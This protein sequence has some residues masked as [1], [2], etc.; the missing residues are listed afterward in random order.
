MV[1]L[2]SEKIDQWLSSQENQRDGFE[3]ERS[4]TQAMQEISLEVFQLSVG[5]VPK[6]K[7]QKKTS[8][9]SWKCSG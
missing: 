1:K 7:N 6:N 9:L 3:Y 4:F 5:K 2:F 8:D